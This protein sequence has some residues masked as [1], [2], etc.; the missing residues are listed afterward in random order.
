MGAVIQI[1]ASDFYASL[2]QLKYL[3]IEGDVF[4]SVKTNIKERIKKRRKL[5]SLDQY[6]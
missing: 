6:L 2:V 5:E 1:P 3:K 4:S